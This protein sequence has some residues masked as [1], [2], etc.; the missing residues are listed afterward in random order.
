MC[1]YH[2]VSFRQGATW[3]DGCDLKCECED[4]STGYYRCNQRYA[5][6]LCQIVSKVV[7]QTV[8]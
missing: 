3:E 5:G 7:Q 8:P 4:S 1:V 6:L 2:G